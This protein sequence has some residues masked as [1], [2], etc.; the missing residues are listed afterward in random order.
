M[1]ELADGPK[2]LKISEVLRPTATSEKG[3]AS[4]KNGVKAKAVSSKG[5]ERVLKQAET[6]FKRTEETADAGIALEFISL[7]RSKQRKSKSQRNLH[8][9]NKISISCQ[10]M[11]RFRISVGAALMHC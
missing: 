5:F 1:K 2:F 4:E 7:S 6:E 3:S 11:S 8:R 10:I 9:Q